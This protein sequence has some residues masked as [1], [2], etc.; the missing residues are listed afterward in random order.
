MPR[1]D[2][3]TMNY[4]HTNKKFIRTHHSQMYLLFAALA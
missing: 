2:T 1:M 4:G 3:M